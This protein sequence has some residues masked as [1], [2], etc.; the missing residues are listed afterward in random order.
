MADTL[1]VGQPCPQFHLPATYA[2]ILDLKDYK[3]KRSLLLVIYPGV[4]DGPSARFF[5]SLRDA[6]KEIKALG[7]EVIA[8]GP[9]NQ[10]L[11]SIFAYKNNLPFPFLIDEARE[12]AK[13]FRAM[14]SDGQTIETTVYVVDTSGI[15]RL[16]EPGHPPVERL[17][18]ALR[19]TGPAPQSVA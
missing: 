3:G 16:A 13:M 11:Q 15:I 7:A 2:K 10:R 6:Y 14:G 8:I 1:A 9:D 18:E 19:A 17:V 5:K 12:H 4:N